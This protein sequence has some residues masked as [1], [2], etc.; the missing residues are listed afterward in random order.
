MEYDDASNITMMEADNTSNI[1]ADQSTFLGFD[2]KGPKTTQIGW[3][4]L[5]D[6]DSGTSRTEIHTTKTDANVIADSMS[7][8]I[9]DNTTILID[10]N[11]FLSNVAKS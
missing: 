5:I 2:Q 10:K 1:T 11:E 6:E 7:D 4:T 8:T 9:Y 3:N